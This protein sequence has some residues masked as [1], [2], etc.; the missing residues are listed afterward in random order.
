MRSKEKAAVALPPQPWWHAAAASPRFWLRIFV[1]F[2]LLLLAAEFSPE[3]ST[4]GDDAKYYLLGKSLVAGNGYRDVFDP[5]M[6]VHTQ[7]PPLYPVFL[8]LLG[9]AT[10]TPL[11]PKIGVGILAAGIL[12]L[13]FYCLRRGA[14]ASLTL[15]LVLIVAFSF[16]LAS[17]ATLLLSEIPYLFATLAAFAL[18]ELYRQR[19]GTGLVFWAA[20]G[21]AVMPAFIRTVGIAFVAAWV[22]TNIVDRNYRQAAAH[23]LVFAV[24]MLLLRLSTGWHS[25]YLTHLFL[26]NSYDPELGFVTV[27]EMISRISEN[28]SLYLSLA[29]PDA[30]LH[31]RPG[32]IPGM[33]LCCALTIPAATGW[34]R[35]FWLPTR[36][37]SYY[38]LFYGAIL[39]LWQTQ[40]S[41]ERF[42]VPVVP[43]IA[44]FFLM[45]LDFICFKIVRRA[46][47]PLSRLKS[48]IIWGAALCIVIPNVNSHRVMIQQ[49][50]GMT[51]D[52]K[53]FYSCADWIRCNTPPDA[54]VAS[55]KP[56]L[57]YLRSL[58]RGFVYPLSHDVEKVIAGLKQGNARYCVLDNFSWSNTTVRYLYPAVMSHPEMFRVVYSLRNPDTDIL[59][60][61]PK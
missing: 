60:F 26:R 39:S 23:L 61:T 24:A 15:P 9:A 45:G 6:S 25:P 41:G 10:N 1:V 7:Y 13:L 55:R 31:F 36:F 18:L 37:L 22:V 17:H 30:M 20:A 32:K 3:I 34:I 38:C 5:Q 56:E 27:P 19:G 12:L 51:K 42:L 33:I 2:Q 35:N 40:F 48:I 52:W 21:A 8:G 44:L 53:N 29:I 28:V 50:S 16:S 47:V 59:E 57:F 49:N 54:I 43:F 4:N 58:R 11:V 14:T 46:R